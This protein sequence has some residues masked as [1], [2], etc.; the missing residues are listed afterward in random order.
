MRKT[1]TTEEF[2]QKVR[3]IHGNKYDY[4]KLEYVN[5]RTKVIII[6][7]KHGEF[8]QTPN[9]HSKGS[10]CLKCRHEKVGILK[11]KTQEDFI[12][13]AKQVHDDRYDYSKVNYFKNSTK[14]TIIC[15]VHGEFQQTP[16][17]HLKGSGCKKCSNLKFT[18]TKEQFIENAIKI[19]GNK[20]N[21]S[22]VEYILS[23]QKVIIICP[24]HGEFLQTPNSHSSQECGCPVCNSSKGELKI[25]E[26][27]EKNKI[28]FTIQEWFENSKTQCIN[29]K[30]GFSLLFD[31]YLPDYNL[32]IEYDGEQHF[33][34]VNW[35]GGKEGLESQQ[36]RDQIKN[37]Y[38]KDNN[39][40][41]LRI[42]WN[43]FNNIEEILKGKIN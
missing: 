41:L 11:R 21:Y 6:C 38:C 36:Y 37:Q 17:N 40:E 30:T 24:E 42:R 8:L 14:V 29:P 39:I 34:S 3:L 4:S 18:L 9:G 12:K 16:A 15:P 19:H 20:Y 23:N 28:N 32:A 26:Y 33:R 2:I 25:C 10:G 27:L 5:N 22:K 43:Q 13:K 7:P 31:F 1:L 35:F